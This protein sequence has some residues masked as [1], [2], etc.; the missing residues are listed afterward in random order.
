MVYGF[1]RQVGGTATIK[2]VPGQ[3]TTVHLYLRRAVAPPEMRQIAFVGILPV[4]SLRIL[5][6]DDDD[7]VRGLA[8]EMLEEMGHEVVDAASGRSARE[9][10][11]EGYHCDLLLVDFAMPLMNGSE[12]ATEARKLHPDLS[13]LFMTGYVDNAV[14]ADDK[15]AHPTTVLTAD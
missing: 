9:L 3:G 12:C 6:V 13:I 10:L 5:V 8:K 11:K 1:A 7:I 2:S 15:S 4:S 14:V